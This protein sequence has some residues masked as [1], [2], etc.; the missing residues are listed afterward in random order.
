[1]QG[2]QPIA[3]IAPSP[4]DAN[5]PPRELTTCPPIRSPIV[6]DRRARAE[7]RGARRG[8]Q[9]AR[10]AGVERSPRPAQDGDVQESRQVEAEDD[11]DDATD[12]PQRR[13]VVDEG[14]GREGRSDAEDREH[15]PESGHVRER[16]ADREPARGR[17]ARGRAR[18]RDRR[19]LAE[20]RRHERQHARRQEADDAGGEGDEDREVRCRPSVGQAS[21]TS[22]RRRRS[23]AAL[24][25]SSSRRSP[26][27][28]TGID[29]E[30]RA[31]PGGIGLDVAL[32]EGRA[33]RGRRALAAP[34]ARWRIVRVSSH[35][36]QPARPYRTR[37]GRGDV[38]HLAVD[39][40]RGLGE[41]P[42]TA[43]YD[44]VRAP[45]AQWTER[46]RPKACVGGSSPSGGA[47]F[48]P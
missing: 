4:N 12:G 45:V 5:Q 47:R 1:M 6:G 43:R 21:R 46:G 16:V 11:E 31:L 24:V 17:R 2:L 27:S 33:R 23:F 44:G 30:E 36:P 48:L 7:G 34:G 28:T 25:A 40:R 9:R 13:Q 39:C 3:K 41:G 14:T 35:R 29:A 22:V 10:C 20:V 8:R 26:S 37:S 18:D 38:A 19:Q 32:D 42:L 15:G